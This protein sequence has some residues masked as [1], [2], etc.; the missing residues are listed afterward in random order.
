[1]Q[2][3]LGVPVEAADQIKRFQE[4]FESE[5]YAALLDSARAGIRA[6]VVQFDSLS[7]FDP[8]LA[9]TVL[10]EPER[11][12]KAAALAI[13]QFDIE[14]KH[15]WTVRFRGLPPSAELPISEIRSKH[16]GALLQLRGIV[17]RK[18]DVRP[19][20][21]S[22]RFECPSCGAVLAVLQFEK[23]FREPGRCGCG[24]K[25]KFRLLSKELVDAQGIVLEEIPE[26]LEGG[27]QPKRLDVLLKNDL[28]APMSDKRTNPGTKVIVSG[29][30]KEIPIPAREGGQL[31]RF[32]L[33]LEGNWIEPLEESFGE[34]AIDD[35]DRAK[36]EELAADPK[37]YEK[38]VASIAP[39]IY[40][41]ERIK[42]A[43]LLQ[44]LGG[45]R[46]KGP[47]GVLRRGDIHI[48]LIG[49]PGSGKSV[50]LKRILMVA[51]KARYVSGK[52]TTGAGV[53]AAV[54]RDEFL[55]GWALEAGALVLAN[56]GICLID[57]LDKMN[58]E[59]RSAMHEGLEQQSISIAKAN[60]QATLRCETTVLAA[61]NPKFG[62]FDPYD[63]VPNQIDLPPTLINRFDLIFPIKDIPSE[64]KDRELATFI[65]DL[66]Q[67]KVAQGEIDTELLRKYIA[68]A[69]RTCQP[70]LTDVAV[71]E[72]KEYFLKMRATG[73]GE[74]S[75]IKAV[76]ISARQ[77]EGLVR[78]AEASA[79]SR[80]SDK[81]TKKDARRAIEIVHYCLT[82][83]GI[84]PETGR[85]D[86]DRITT[87][88]SAS[89][90]NKIHALKEAMTELESKFGKMIPVDELVRTATSKGLEEAEIEE[91]LE[92]LKR[93]G[94]I[95]EPRRGFVQRI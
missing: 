38:L 81:I 87:G 10:D 93:E 70:T 30:L 65:L 21:T 83:I 33:I 24:R 75:G 50:L 39:S 40:G 86:I 67:N 22:A 58:K 61:A 9:E 34:L 12:L 7:S 45:V 44:L 84:D 68:W 27:E 94:D 2:R 5:C 51:P 71:A 57:E 78:L 23:K 31:T 47:D 18:T 8:E 35:A 32:E 1:M 60:I 19:Q 26:E 48:L 74:E 15:G 49:D 85:F 88:I 20:V 13:E 69:R 3:K 64:A 89:Q 90:R 79:R 55:G 53:T 62:R 95:F 63:A 80:L 91:F 29:V 11:A 82:Q 46:K 73:G 76:P 52:G 54:V 92:R 56:K 16:I 72:L 41:H 77:L 36:I 14:P 25:G 43:L 66:H 28:V 42:E 6:L 17:K 4:F 37:C 59:D